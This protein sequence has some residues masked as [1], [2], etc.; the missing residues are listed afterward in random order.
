[1]AMIVLAGQRFGRWKVLMDWPMGPRAY[2]LCV[3]ECGNGDL[4]P[5]WCLKSGDSRS[6]GC[7][8]RE[9]AKARVTTHGLSDLPE[10]GIWCGMINRTSNALSSPSTASAIRYM[11]RGM[12][13]E[14]RESFERFYADMGPR[15]SPRHTIERYDNDGPYAPW[16]CGWEL[17]RP[18]AQNRVSTRYVTYNG[19]RMCVTEAERQAG[20]PLGTVTRRARAGWPEADWFL[21]PRK[22]RPSAANARGKI[23]SR[24]ARFIPATIVET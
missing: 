11:E 20:L 6:C 2:R 19:E 23:P 15:P 12:C 17:P 24:V 9:V 21:P 18:Q 7:L 16:N 22:G 5:G 14:W 4:V 1:M 3:C 8:N 10:Y 13:K